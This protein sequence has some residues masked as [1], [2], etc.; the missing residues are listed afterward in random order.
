MHQEE[1]RGGV[2]RCWGGCAPGSMPYCMGIKCQV[3]NVKERPHNKWLHPTSYNKG[4][5][6]EKL[7]LSISGLLLNTRV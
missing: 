2:S 5:Y 6:K 3:S 1:D 7:Q 4:D